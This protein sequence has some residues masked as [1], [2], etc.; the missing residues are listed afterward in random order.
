MQGGREGRRK[1]G[2]RWEML[3]FGRNPSLSTP[4]ETWH[5]TGN[6]IIVFT[7]NKVFAISNVLKKFADNGYFLL[8]RFC[9][10]MLSPYYA[11]IS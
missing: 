10:M 11:S 8:S 4:T 9:A 5:A 2:K 1:E 6:F 7:A 3:I